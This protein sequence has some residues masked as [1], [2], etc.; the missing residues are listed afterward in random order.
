VQTSLFAW[1]RT[2]STPNDLPSNPGSVPI[3]HTAAYS[4]AS[5]NLPYGLLPEPRQDRLVSSQSDFS[6]P[7]WTHP[8]HIPPTIRTSHQCPE[9][10]RVFGYQCKG[11]TP[12]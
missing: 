2:P 4:F 12:A 9:R 11:I 5:V 1:S 8:D 3:D 6:G 7:P 10:L